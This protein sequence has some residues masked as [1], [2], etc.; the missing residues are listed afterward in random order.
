MVLGGSPQHLV[1]P[2]CGH[3]SYSEGA[4]LCRG[5]GTQTR[6]SSNRSATWGALLGGG[7]AC[8]TW[9]NFSILSAWGTGVPE[10]LGRLQSRGTR[11]RARSR[12]PEGQQHVTL[13]LEPDQ[14]QDWKQVTKAALRAIKAVISPPTGHGGNRRGTRIRLKCCASEE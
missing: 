9:P 3:C 14:A 4:L 10:K 6:R 5:L 13:W 1:S 8:V 2:Q 11:T 12:V 7:N